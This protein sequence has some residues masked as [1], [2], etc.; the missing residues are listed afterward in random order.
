MYIALFFERL[1]AMLHVDELGQTAGT[2]VEEASSD[3]CNEEYPSFRS[4][5]PA[6]LRFPS[7][8][9]GYCT[10]TQLPY[11]WTFSFF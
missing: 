9:D 3:D 5:R 2:F 6:R 10:R 8:N 7:N 4:Q 1:I 11:T